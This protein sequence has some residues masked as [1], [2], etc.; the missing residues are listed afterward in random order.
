MLVTAANCYSVVRRLVAAP[1]LAVDTETTGL[2][3]Y[4]GDRAFS[5][6]VADEDDAYY[7]D[8]NT[9]GWQASPDQLNEFMSLPKVWYLANAKFD[10]AFLERLGLDLTG[11]IHD[12]Q[13]HERLLDSTLFGQVFDLDSMAQRYGQRKDAAVHEW[14]LKNKAWTDAPGGGKK[15]ERRLHFDRVP[16]D[17]IVP[18]GCKDGRITFDIGRKQEAR[19]VASELQGVPSLRPLVENERAL[20]RTVYAMERAGVKINR[21]FCLAAANYEETR[22]SALAQKFR[23]MTGRDFVDSAKALA[24]C[25]AGVRLLHTAKGAPSFC[26]EA[27]ATYD[28]PLTAV[29]SD[30]RDAKSKADY[31]RGFLHH[32]AAAGRVHAS[33]NQHQAV[34]GR[35]S[36]SSPN[37]QNLTRPEEGTPEGAFEVRRAIVPEDGFFLAM[38]DFDQMEYRLMLEYAGC[39]ALIQKVL[40]GL[41]VHAA[42]ALLAGITRQQAKTTNF[43]TI[44]GG[45]DATLAAKLGLSIG[46]AAKVRGAI[47]AAAPE[48]RD[49]IRACV[50]R[51]ESRGFVFNWFG[52]RQY[53]PDPRTAYRAPNHIIQGGCADVVKIA[54]NR[55]ADRLRGMK[56]KL[57][58]C[59]HDELVFEVAFGEEWVLP[60]LREIME[61]VY[62]HTWLKLTAGASYSFKNLGEKIKGYPGGN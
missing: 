42:T 8:F 11:C 26:A 21:D 35:F 43:L 39:V 24:P 7:F 32:M 5:L 15:K 19:L 6:I 17:L 3:P 53:F 47:F 18:Y 14:I 9:N 48:I 31:Y 54:M 22:R 20:T 49:F 34:T 27:L 2:R 13:T 16:H 52:R 50:G 38:F 61:T 33:F 29:V 58:L 60:E 1:E 36:S 51:A 56:T 4:H 44:Y 23:E 45:G 46:D 28:H 57:V 25:F 10:L 40:G 55:C 37:L 12:L 41:D 62:P 59:V 30:I